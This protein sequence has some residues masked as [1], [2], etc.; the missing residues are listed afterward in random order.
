LAPMVGASLEVMDRDA[1][2]MRGERPFVFSNLKTGH[3]LAE[4]IGFIETAGM[5]ESRS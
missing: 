5:L 3:G 2:K 1:K 4:I